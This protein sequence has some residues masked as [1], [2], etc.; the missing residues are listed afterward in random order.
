MFLLHYIVH[1]NNESIM[2]M[3]VYV[4]Y[5]ALASRE[6]GQWYGQKQET[7]SATRQEQHSQDD[8]RRRG[9]LVTASTTS[10]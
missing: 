6:F 10:L 3:A 4:G 9:F 5:W 8:S 1:L 7:Q 2:S